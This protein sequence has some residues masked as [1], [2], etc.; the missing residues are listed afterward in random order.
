MSLLLIF[1]G[2][3]W[4]INGRGCQL[5]IRRNSQY[6]VHKTQ[7][8]DKQNKKQHNICVG[9][10]HTKDEDKQ[11]KQHKTIC[12]RRHYAQTNTKS[13]K[14]MSNT[15]LTKISG[16]SQV[17]AKGKQF[18]LLIKHTPIF[19]F[20]WMVDDCLFA[21]QFSSDH[22]IVCPPSI[23]GFWLSLCYL[24]H[25]WKHLFLQISWHHRINNTQVFLLC[26]YIFGIFVLSD[27]YIL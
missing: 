9:H 17:F 21:C 18:L 8:E 19:N 7:D 11:N 5:T 25:L 23:C 27:T 24:R 22:C 4:S 13:T 10:H 1:V 6:W 3:C 2:L 12:I 15:D 14:K 16:W 20:L 26:K